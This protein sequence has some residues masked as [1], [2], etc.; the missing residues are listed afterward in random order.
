MKRKIIFILGCIGILNFATVLTHASEVPDTQLETDASE[1]L[2]NQD[3][4]DSKELEKSLMNGI[5]SLP[6]DPEYV[7]LLEERMADFYSPRYEAFSY[8]GYTHNDKFKDCKIRNGVDVSRYQGDINWNSVNNSGM[9]Y[10]FIRVGY[11]GYSGGNLVED[12]RGKDNIQNALNAGM[13]V[14][15]YIFSQA[16]TEAEAIEEADFA[17]SKISGYDITMPIVIDYEYVKA[18]RL[19]NA[20]LSREQATAIVN[21]FC[22]RI[23]QAGYTP[24]VYANKSMLEDSLNAGNIPHKIWLANY[25]NQTTYAGDYEYWQY[26]ESGKVDGITGNVDCDFWYDSS[27]DA[28]ITGVYIPDDDAINIRAGAIINTDDSHITYEC[29]VIDYDYATYGTAFFPAVKTTADKTDNWMTYTPSHP[30]MYGFCWRAYKNGKVISEYGAT[31]YFAGNQISNAMIY[32][33]DRNAQTLDFGMVFSATDKENVRIQWFVY[34]PD[35]GV[36]ES[37]L[38][39]DLVKNI[40][41]CQKWT[42][43]SG[44]YWIMC[45]VTATNNP[46][47]TMCWGVEIRDGKVID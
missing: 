39:D 18:G 34:K 41:V 20:N 33:P 35:E 8:E 9:E 36:Y 47:S 15:A 42:K 22:D 46:A 44:R 28:I 30:G 32:V 43:K 2:N 11:R 3:E 38:A 10:A 4:M 45:R 31:H 7:K 21:A 37:I 40:G 16:I 12:S 13:K 29:T 14:G 25:T 23:Q 24:M 19:Q 5:E 6:D 26:T 27:N 17:L 1:V